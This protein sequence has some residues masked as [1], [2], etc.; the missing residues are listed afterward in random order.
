[1]F[2]TMM[3]EELQPRIFIERYYGIANL[4]HS[5]EELVQK[6]R[7]KNGSEKEDAQA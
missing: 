7:K 3:I 4:R 1:M 2:D 5:K 6:K